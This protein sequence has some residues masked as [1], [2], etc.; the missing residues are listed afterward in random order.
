MFQLDTKN[1]TDL[2]KIKEKRGQVKA[3]KGERKDAKKLYQNAR[4]DKNK[5][6]FPPQKKWKFQF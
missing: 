5:K 4:N 6:W 3:A 1:L 2:L